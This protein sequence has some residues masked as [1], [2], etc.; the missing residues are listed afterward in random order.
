VLDVNWLTPTKIRELSVLGERGMFVVDYLARSL[1]SYENDHHQHEEPTG[2]AARHTKGVSEG[3][4]HD[5]PIEKREPLRVELEA[6]V[7]AVRTGGPAPVSPD[8]ALAA[9]EAAEAL[10]RA[11]ASGEGVVLPVRASA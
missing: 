6:F 2:W 10:V 11:G 8:D 9:M 5:I 1:T 3:P 7:E 4:V